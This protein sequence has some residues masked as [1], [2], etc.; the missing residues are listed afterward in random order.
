MDRTGKTGRTAKDRDG[1][2]RKEGQ[3]TGGFGVGGSG[4][5]INF[6]ITGKRHISTVFTVQFIAVHVV[7]LL[8]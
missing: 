4:G 3:E 8:M 6:D 5:S 2:D 7:F 1:K